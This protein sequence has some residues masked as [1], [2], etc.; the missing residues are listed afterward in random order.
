MSNFKQRD[1][2]FLFP[3]F[4]LP[5]FEPNIVGALEDLSLLHS[6]VLIWQCLGFVVATVLFIL[7]N[8]VKKNLLLWIL[9]LMSVILIISTIV[10]RADVLHSLFYSLEIFSITTFCVYYVDYKDSY[11]RVINVLYWYFT[12]I[13]LL[14]LISMVLYPGQDSF[15]YWVFSNKNNHIYYL[16]PY[17]F[18]SVCRKTP[19]KL[20]TFRSLF[21]PYVI[22]LITI[23]L[24]HSTTSLFSLMV[25]LLLIIFYSSG[26]KKR[27][28][29][30]MYFFIVSVIISYVFIVTNY[31]VYLDAVIS[32]YDKEDTFGR[33]VIWEKALDFIHSSPWLGIGLESEEDMIDIFGYT[34][35]H[36]KYLDIA[37][38]GGI[39]SLILFLLFIFFVCKDINKNKN[40]V[41]L[42]ASAILCAYAVEFMMEG[43]RA[44]MGFYLVFF[45]L[46]YSYRLSL[47]TKNN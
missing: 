4:V 15:D 12:I 3:L 11:F 39:T 26:S 29:I 14:N 6:I 36:N 28:S 31:I 34:H 1:N 43:K 8:K 44:D 19:G 45:L 16:L 24:G 10:N 9:S 18:L 7:C 25:I 42:I 13:V 20:H 2:F 37:Y 23:L 17:L 46:P 41:S 33:F 47:N 35:C 5:F 21:F 32:Y 40:K 30:I 22:S 27:K 38:I